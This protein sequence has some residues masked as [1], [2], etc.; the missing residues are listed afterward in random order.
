L[1]QDKD[2]C[3]WIVEKGSAV[4]SAGL[5]AVHARLLH[6]ALTSRSPAAIDI[7]M[8]RFDPEYAKDSKPAAG[9]TTVN[10][11]LTQ[12]LTM[13]SAE[14]EAYVRNKRRTNGFADDRGK[15]QVPD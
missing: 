2:A 9:T 6:L 7:Y 5:G 8:R 14:L 15:G 4:A 11:Q 1:L 12:I 13:S 10:S 3:K